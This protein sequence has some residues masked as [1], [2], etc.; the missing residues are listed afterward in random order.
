[1][2]RHHEQE[3]PQAEFGGVAYMLKR[4]YCADIAKGPFQV[5][6]KEEYRG[7]LEM[8]KK[9]KM[10]VWHA[11]VVKNESGRFFLG[12]LHVIDWESVPDQAYD[13]EPPKSVGYTPVAESPST[14]RSHGDLTCPVCNFKASSTSGYTLHMKKHA[15]DEAK[16]EAAGDGALVCPVCKKVCSST[17]GLTLHKKSHPEL[18][19]A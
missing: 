17:S 19:E 12:P 10:Y 14:A 3:K 11:D 16:A 7:L 1:M 6:D 15:A 18:V 9:E 4:P 2:P 13:V 5:R 8:A